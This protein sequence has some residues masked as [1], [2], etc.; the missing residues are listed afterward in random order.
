M[1][2]SLASVSSRVST[3]I[4][5]P[6]PVPTK[7]IRSQQVSRTTGLTLNQQRRINTR[8]ARGARLLDEQLP[9]WRGKLA[10]KT[11]RR[12]L[13]A[14]GRLFD[15]RNVDVGDGG[16]YFEHG[17]YANGDI[18]GSI[19]NEERGLALAWERVLNG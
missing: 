2:A 3:P 9:G 17:S 19:K 4:T 6:P 7:P 10:G 14:V 11:G 18:S 16:Y 8:V 15:N 5:A 1:C 12:L 13:S